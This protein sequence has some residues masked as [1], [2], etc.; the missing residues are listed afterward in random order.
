MS[1][2]FRKQLHSVGCQLSEYFDGFVVVGFVAGTNEAFVLTDAD[3]EKTAY[4]LNLLL[5]KAKIPI[6]EQQQT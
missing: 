1:K 3:D 5:D 2:A 4:G 6:E